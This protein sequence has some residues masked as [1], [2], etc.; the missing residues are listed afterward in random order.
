MIH[1]S[2]KKESGSNDDD[3][4]M[5][6]TAINHEIAARH[7][8]ELQRAYKSRGEAYLPNGICR[9]VRGECIRNV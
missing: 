4:Y 5:L 1:K 2:Y 7:K 6:K 3:L 8:A 9:N